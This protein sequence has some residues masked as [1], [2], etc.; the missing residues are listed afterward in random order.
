MGAFETLGSLQLT[1]GCIFGCSQERF[2][3]FCNALNCYQ[4]H[5]LEPSACR[6]CADWHCLG[7]SCLAAS[8]PLPAT[9]PQVL[10]DNKSEYAHVTGTMSPFRLHLQL[11]GTPC[12]CRNTTQPRQPPDRRVNGRLAR[13]HS[14]N[15]PRSHTACLKKPCDRQQAAPHS[16]ASTLAAAAAAAT[17]AARAPLLLLLRT[18]SGVACRRH[19]V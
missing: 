9:G 15:L 7:G 17:T 14:T 6:M 1:V 11:T 2:F 12:R 4:R 3:C 18:S 13:W 19:A 5:C 8:N 16:T 10:E